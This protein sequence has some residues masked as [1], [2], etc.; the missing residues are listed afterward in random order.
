MLWVCIDLVNVCV[1]ALTPS[2][3]ERML[4]STLKTSVPDVRWTEAAHE[5]HIPTVI[6]P[7]PASGC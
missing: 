2:M 4:Y 1:R 7:F 6:D 3:G 5:K